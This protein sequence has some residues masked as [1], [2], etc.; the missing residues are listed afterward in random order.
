MYE[1]KKRTVES[2]KKELLENQKEEVT[3]EQTAKATKIT[4]EGDWRNGR[5]TSAPWEK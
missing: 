5:P 1:K 3:I 4:I 2:V